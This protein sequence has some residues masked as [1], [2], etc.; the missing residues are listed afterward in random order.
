MVTD[1]CVICIFLVEAV[2]V[3]WEDGK[4]SGILLCYGLKQYS[5]AN[6]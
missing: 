3:L 1:F 4:C 6:S 5:P 2:K